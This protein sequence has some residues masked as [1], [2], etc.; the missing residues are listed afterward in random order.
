VPIAEWENM[1][2][3]V[4]PEGELELNNQDVDPGRPIYVTI[5]D[6][7]DSGT[8]VRSTGDPV[9]QGFGTLWHRGFANGYVIKLPV[10]YWTIGTGGAV[11]P[12]TELTN[13]TAQEMDDL[14][15]RHYRSIFNG[16]GRLFYAPATLPIRLA[17]DLFAI[18]K[19]QLTE[20]QI[21][22]NTVLQFGS[23]LP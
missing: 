13:P 22:T 6:G 18:A 21:N 7:A 8:D 12:A 14:L 15:M 2:L 1:T 23:T 19:P 16:G 17:D 5:K 3:L 4:T 20:A 9:P 11:V 10:E